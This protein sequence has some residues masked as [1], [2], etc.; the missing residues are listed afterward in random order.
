MIK[1]QTM[2]LVAISSNL[3]F[4]LMGMFRGSLRSV[5]SSTGPCRVSTTVAKYK[6]HKSKY[7]YEELFR[8]K[9]LHLN[10]KKLHGLREA[11]E[12]FVGFFHVKKRIGIDLRY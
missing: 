5:I 12:H 7:T 8:S 3:A 4:I 2:L 1:G 10:F 11:L 6:E 9:K